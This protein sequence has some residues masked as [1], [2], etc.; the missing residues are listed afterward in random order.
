MGAL[1]RDLVAEAGRA[2]LEVME[3]GDVGPAAD[4]YRDRIWELDVDDAREAL[5]RMC[6]AAAVE[7]LQTHR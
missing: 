7:A 2:V 6:T 3:H 4:V 1:C 5:G